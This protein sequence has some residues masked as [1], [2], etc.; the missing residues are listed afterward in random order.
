VHAA[1]HALGAPD[2]SVRE[3]AKE[4]LFDALDTG[5]SDD[6]ALLILAAAQRKGADADV[7]T[8][9]LL[10]GFDADRLGHADEL[11]ALALAHPGSDFQE[12]LLEEMRDRFP[13]S[14]ARVKVLAAIAARGDEPSGQHA[15][16][17]LAATAELSDETCAALAA[18]AR[19][20]PP[21]LAVFA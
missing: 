16:V 20:A 6:D 7:L 13:R 19:S 21:R 12:A 11:R 8:A 3:H 4:V 10:E 15:V 18:T 1:A 2:R 5:F 14:R 17:G 9:R